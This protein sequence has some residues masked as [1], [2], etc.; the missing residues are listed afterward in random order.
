MLVERVR[1]N[2]HRIVAVG[3]NQA[4]LGNTWWALQTRLDDK[5][6]QALLLWL[7]STLGILLLYGSR[8]ITEGAWVQMKKPAWAA[9]PTLDVRVL[10]TAQLDTL[11][12]TYATL[13]TQDLLAIAKLR[14]DPVRKQID[15]AI[16]AVLEL[17]DLTD[18]REMLGREPGLSGQPLLQDANHR[19]QIEP[20]IEIATES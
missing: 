18:L 9:M 2:T 3:L 15:D 20:P 6:K 11:A 16:G 17:P 10:S 4:A 8:V 14:S 7:N 1:L 12:T 19:S 13:A 5:Q